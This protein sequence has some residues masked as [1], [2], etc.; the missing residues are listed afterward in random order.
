MGSYTF[1][2]LSL[3]ESSFES[4]VS[5]SDSVR[6]KMGLALGALWED[7]RGDF[8]GNRVRNSFAHFLNLK[9]LNSY[10]Y[11]KFG[12]DITYGLEDPK[13]RIDR[14]SSLPTNGSDSPT[15]HPVEKSSSGGKF[16]SF[17]DI[18]L[19]ID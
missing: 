13:L 3:S 6:K 14:I 10:K 2:I 15:S 1:P 16:E 12:V 7:E 17:L 5:A 18:S 11:E 19:K 9:S 8:C 4:L